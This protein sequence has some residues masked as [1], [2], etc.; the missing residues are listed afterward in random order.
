M[1]L[2]HTRGEHIHLGN[3]DGVGQRREL[4]VG[5]GDADIIHVDERQRTHAAACQR[6]DDPG[7]HTAHAY[8]GHMRRGQPWQRR[9]PVKP[10]NAAKALRVGFIHAF[11]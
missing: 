2:C 1:D 3:T 6:L 7:A 5:V 4:A 11:V 8:D 9:S 10:P